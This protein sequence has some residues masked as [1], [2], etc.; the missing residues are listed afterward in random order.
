MLPLTCIAFNDAKIDDFG[1]LMCVDMRKY[2]DRKRK[3]SLVGQNFIELFLSVGRADPKASVREVGRMF[4]EKLNQMKNDSTF[5][6]A[7]YDMDN[8]FPK[9][10]KRLYVEISNIGRF[11]A[12]RPIVDVFIQQSLNIKQA[13]WLA[14]FASFSRNT[15]GEDTVNIRFE[16]PQTALSYLDGEVMIKSLAHSMTEIPSDVKK[17]IYF[18]N[19]CIIIKFQYIKKY[20]KIN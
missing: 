12:K 17:R 20:I 5:Y 9:L 13:E 15:Q 4:R 7:L 18:L 10:E 19:D 11:N 3:S 1:V 8:G 16:R 6:G 2:M 14:G